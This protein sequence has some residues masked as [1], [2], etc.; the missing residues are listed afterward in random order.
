[1]TG[2][3]RR[4]VEV[5]LLGELGRKF[6]RTYRFMAIN[7]KEVLSALCRQIPGF[8]EYLSR[9]HENG[10][11]FKLVTKEPEGIDY[12]GI[13]M[14]C[15]KLVIAPVIT[16]AGGRGLSIGTILVGVALIALSFVS[17]GAGAWAGIGGWS[18]A[19]G[20]TGAWTA[21][22]SLLAFKLGVALVLTGI[23]GLLMPPVQTPTSDT[24][25][26]ESFIFDRAAELTTQGYPVPLLYGRY[27]VDSPLVVYSAI[28]TEQIPV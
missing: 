14:S 10:V 26:K 16:G 17:F 1:M 28:A 20:T 27:L 4:F 3:K 22:G 21:G 9:A 6:G 12:E 18:G 2:T 25:K 13:F 11:G 8:S 24:K 19:A 7:A 5:K 15:N 23:A